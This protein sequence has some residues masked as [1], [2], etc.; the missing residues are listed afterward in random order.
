MV[1]N[2]FDDAIIH[3]VKALIQF[4]IISASPPMLAR[5]ESLRQR[6]NMPRSECDSRKID[7]LI[8][9]LL[10][11]SLRSVMKQIRK[12]LHSNAIKPFTQRLLLC[13]QTAYALF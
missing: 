7:S 4:P 11:P 5:N 3:E 13:T 1:I 2:Y 6:F 8:L 10:L 12:C 9:Q